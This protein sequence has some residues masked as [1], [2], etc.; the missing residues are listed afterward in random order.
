MKVSST[1]T[2]LLVSFWNYLDKRH[3][4]HSL[5]ILILIIAVSLAEVISIGA[6]L[7]FL[8]MLTAPELIYQNALMQPIVQT[9]GLNS[10]SELFLPITIGFVS[11]AL[12]AGVMRI[13]LLSAIN[14]FERVVGTDLNMDVYRNT[15]YQSYSNHIARNSSY[16]ISLIT[17]KT[18]VVIRGVFKAAL[19][20]VSSVIILI[21]IVSILI[22]INV[23]VALGALVGFGLMYWSIARYAR[24]RRT[25]NSQCITKEHANLIKIL[26]EGMGG[27]RDILISANQQF[28]CSLFRNSDTKVRRAIADNDFIAASPRFAIE[29][30]G[31]T[32]VAILAYYLSQEVS[33]ARDIVPVL[34]AMAMGA[35]RLLPVLQAIYSSA[36]SIDGSR[37]SLQEVL[38][39]LDRISPICTKQP[40]EIPMLFEKEIRLSHLSFRY[41]KN[42]P[43][44]LNRINLTLK[45]GKCI[46]FVG[47]TGS[48]KST[49]LDIIMGLLI[50]TEGALMID[51]KVVTIE[52]CQNWQVHVAHVPQNIY[53]SDT[54]I[55]ENI[56]F[57]QS[58]DQIDHDRVRLASHQAR[59]SELIESWPEQ[60]QTFVG[61]RGIR[62]SGG[63]RQ[64]I[65][66]AR[67][68]Y[69]KANV[70]ILDEATSALDNK[71]EKEV[72]KAIEGL[73]GKLTVLIIAH[74][75]T[76]LKNCDQIFELNSNTSFRLRKYED[77]VREFS[78]EN[79]VDF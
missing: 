72:M 3:K 51:D 69:R 58:I 55:E 19:T 68:L 7:P 36:S 29:S 13:T 61:E 49:F 38:N 32:L 21:G 31:M 62:L 26:Q 12:I 67:A 15:L 76:T 34:G 4:R 59:I 46:G 64:R 56:A 44:V 28:Y 22:M 6:I 48:G 39:L 50:P 75:I 71:T 52:N 10:A 14:H 20:L 74:R 24:K 57:G 77:L 78:T 63:Q 65:G 16:I 70:L 2:A 33:D 79:N 1:N 18:D 30:L 73:E 23:E 60:Y 41:G 53:L 35:Q 25:I 5:L 40:P 47:G 9:L 37:H 8:G 42:N 45:K 27:I 11:A 17:N 43:L 54:T 66:I